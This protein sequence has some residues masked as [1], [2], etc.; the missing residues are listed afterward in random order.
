MYQQMEALQKAA[1]PKIVLKPNMKEDDWDRGLKRSDAPS[2][3][4]VALSQQPVAFVYGNTPVTRE[5]LGEYLI[6]R[7]GADCIELMV[8]KLVVEKECA[9]RCITVSEA[10]LGAALKKDIEMSKA[11]SLEDFIKNYLRAHRTTLYGYREDVLR[12][13][14]LLAKLSRAN[15]K[16]EAGDLRKASEAYHGEKADC[17]IIMWPRTPQDHEIAVKQYAQIRKTPE[18]FNR[19]AKTQASPH[20]AA[21]GGHIPPFA[22]HTTGNE[23]VE[24][25]VFALREGEITPVVET[26]QG[27]IVARLNRKI[28]AT[29]PPEDPAAAAEER[30][31]WEAEIMDKKSV[32]AIPQEFAKLREA[33]TPNI[34]L[35]A[36]LR[37]EDWIREVKQEIRGTETKPAPKN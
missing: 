11:A 36:A 8:N 28:P 3:D 22:R 10:E 29:K 9:Q 24:K 32:M 20:L 15:V 17:Q 33:A 30:A 21:D 34:L 18:E 27:Y 26:P 19:I 16:V 12:P 7:Y 31:K 4:G 37:E 25:E 13:K 6:A 1:D 2:A 5:Q 35:R 14:L 23:N